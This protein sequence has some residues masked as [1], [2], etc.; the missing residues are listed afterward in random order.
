LVAVLWIRIWI[1]IKLKGYD[2]DLDPRQ[3]HKLD[4][5][6]HQ[7]ADDKPKLVEY[8]PT[9]FEHFSKVVSLKLE[10]RIWIRIRIQVKVRI[11]IPIKVTRRIPIRIRI[12]VTRKDPLLG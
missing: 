8:E 11:W 12:K 6:P 10:A 3:S 1:R 4:P 9:V 7:F 2:P 5:D